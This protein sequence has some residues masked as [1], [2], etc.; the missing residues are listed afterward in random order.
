MSA[1]RFIPLTEAARRLGIHYHRCRN[2]MLA[3]RLRGKQV[4]GRWYVRADD[5]AR[6][7]R[8]LRQLNA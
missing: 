6:L 2:W 4:A 1:P 7:R 5:V 3:R 8:Q